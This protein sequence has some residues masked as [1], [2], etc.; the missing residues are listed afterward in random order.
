[1]SSNAARQPSYVNSE[2]AWD[3]VYVN[4]NGSVASAGRKLDDLHLKGEDLEGAYGVQ[5]PCLAPVLHT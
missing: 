5:N 2:E 3:G 4:S 1:M